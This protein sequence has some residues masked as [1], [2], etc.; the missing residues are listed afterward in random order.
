MF[1]DVNLKEEDLK[2]DYPNISEYDDQT[3][4]KLEKEVAGIYVSGHPL[5]NY[6]DKFSNFT[7]TADM[8]MDGE[9]MESTEDSEESVQVGNG[10]EDGMEVICGGLVV[11][12][13][14]LVSKKSGKEM[15]IIKLEDLY[16]G[17]DAM[18]FP[19]VYA[20][21]KGQVGADSLVT[22]KGKLSIREGER[23]TVLVD[24]IENWLSK[25]AE[26][27]PVE[28]PKTLY[29]KY[30]LQNVQLHEDVYRLLSEY[31][32][33]TPVI[34]KCE[35]LGKS[36]KLNIFVDPQESLLQELHAYIKDEFIKLL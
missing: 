27:K 13:K 31:A 14:R 21:Y 10:L 29:L 3:K 4:L 33:S 2:V 11:E 8:L 34:V 32:G 1:E 28:K 35:T 18:M 6:I 19:N 7:L 9:S 26:E 16:G 23:P 24:S 17:I 12:F 20:K 30:D 36:Y 5:S 25:T 15:A 22:V